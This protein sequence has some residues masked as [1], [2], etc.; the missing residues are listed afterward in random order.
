MGKNRSHGFD[1]WG[2]V[3]EFSQN[4]DDFFSATPTV[5]DNPNLQRNT[6]FTQTDLLQKFYIPLS[7]TTDLKIN[8]QYSTSSDVPRFDRLDER[9]GG[10]LR[11]AEWYYG[12][13]DRLLVSPQLHFKPGKSW[14]N[15]GTFTL[16][17]QN[18]EESR[19]QRRFGSL[20]R[21]IA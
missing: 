10:E 16:A 12:P 13:Q 5:N 19:I 21:T 6:G 20:D 2:L 11:W 14:L 1:D 9:S 17:Y 18:I 15:E 8:L 7:T 3:T 4:T